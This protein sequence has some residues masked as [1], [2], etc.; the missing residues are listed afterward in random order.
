MSALAAIL[1]FSCMANVAPD[2]QILYCQAAKAWAPYR[3][4]I[5][6]VKWC[7]PEECLGMGGG[8]FHYNSRVIAIDPDWPFKG[9]ELL[10]TLEHEYGHALGLQHNWASSIM[11]PGWDQ[12]FAQGPTEDDFKELRRMHGAQRR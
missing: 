9:N 2:L 7:D 5:L 10:L 12:P 4:D 3:A 6:G 11:K 1:V 8:M